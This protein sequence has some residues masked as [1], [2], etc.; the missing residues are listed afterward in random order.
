MNQS[1]DMSGMTAEEAIQVMKVLGKISQIKTE[2]EKRKSQA[3]I[4]ELSSVGGKQK[5]T[6]ATAPKKPGRPKKHWKHKKR[7][8]RT[9]MR[10]YM[11]RK[12]KALIAP[13]RKQLAAEGS[14]YEYYMMEWK[15]RGFK[16]EVTME[17]WEEHVQPRIGDKVPTLFRLN[18]SKPVA[19]YNIL[20][21]DSGTKETIFDGTDWMLNQLGVLTD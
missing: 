9:Y 10:E 1:I 20:V 17:E 18:T 4:N 15:K 12:Y 21:K 13:K 11:N 8:H 14:W 7:V 3:L 6:K 19:L 16:V 2:A 5:L